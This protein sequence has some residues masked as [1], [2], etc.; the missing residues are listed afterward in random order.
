MQVI[1]VLVFLVLAIGLIMA[2][3]DRIVDE[4]EVMLQDEN[5][6]PVMEGDDPV[7]LKLLGFDGKSYR[8]T[9][10]GGDAKICW[11]IPLERGRPII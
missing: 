7:T 6:E 11:Y 2:K 10:K 8:V 9:N 4:A 5:G 1:A 3:L